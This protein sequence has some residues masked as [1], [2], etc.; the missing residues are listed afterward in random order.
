[1]AGPYYGASANTMFY[2]GMFF[3]NQDGTM[4]LS[5]DANL[6]IDWPNAIGNLSH[7]VLCSSFCRS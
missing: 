6:I 7:F 3:D 1:V 4:R 2:G 5:P